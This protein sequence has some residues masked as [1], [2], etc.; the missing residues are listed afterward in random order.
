MET[1]TRPKTLPLTAVREGQAIKTPMN[2]AHNCG[3]NPGGQIMSGGKVVG[4]HF[5]CACG[6]CGI[7]VETRM[8]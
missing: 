2:C 7:I 3:V 4:Q 6:G 1:L 5:T 8:F